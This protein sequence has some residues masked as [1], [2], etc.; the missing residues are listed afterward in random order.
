MR[1]VQ[2]FL[3]T[4]L[5]AMTP[6]SP[7]PADAHNVVRA[8]ESE[9]PKVREDKSY[10]EA[11]F[12]VTAGDSCGSGFAISPRVVVTCWH[13]V[14]QRDRSMSRRAT[15]LSGAGKTTG[16]TLMSY[17]EGADVAMLELD[18]PVNVFFR[19]A[20]EEASVGDH[21]A[22]IR[23]RPN[24]VARFTRAD[25]FDLWSGS[26]CYAGSLTKPMER[27]NSGSPVV[28]ADYEVV[29]I[30]SAILPRDNYR[31]VYSGLAGLKRLLGLHA[32]LRVV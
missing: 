23:S 22:V 28:N 24:Y 11:I 15:L 14:E 32:A 1:I 21:V 10:R 25:I 19:I 30:L 5:A 17:D 31:G 16:A 18:E 26:R 2:F 27:G 29:G 9:R 4:V 3:C 7:Q 6:C 12:K 13:V 8:E 20:A